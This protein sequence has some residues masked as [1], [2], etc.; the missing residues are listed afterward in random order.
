MEKDKLENEKIKYFIPE[1]EYFLNAQLSSLLDGYIPPKQN[2]E[3]NVDFDDVEL[4]DD[5]FFNDIDKRV[6]F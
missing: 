4:L 5:D 2:N 3:S 1:I 6:K